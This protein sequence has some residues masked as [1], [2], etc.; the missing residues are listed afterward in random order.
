LQWAQDFR[1]G[2]MG[3]E[4]IQEAFAE[5]SAPQ[6]V[7]STPALREKLLTVRRELDAIRFGMCERGQEAEINRVFLELEE[8]I[9]R[10]NQ[11]QVPER[12]VGNQREH[13]KPIRL[14]KADR[15]S[16]QPSAKKEKN[17]R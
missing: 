3:I 12:S 5:I 1:D 4:E 10:D 17:E 11:P 16:S 8:V 13:S 15:N 6:A 2:E 14:D 7:G 9:R